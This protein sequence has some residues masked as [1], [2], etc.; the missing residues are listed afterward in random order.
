MS[1]TSKFREDLIIFCEG[2]GLDIGYGGDPI[3]TTSITIDLPIPYTKLGSYP[4][5]LGGDARKLYWFSD[6]SLNYVYSSHCLEDFE[7]TESVLTE[8]LRVLKPG[9]MLVLLL[10]DQQRYEKWC[11]DHKTEPNAAHKI[12]NFSLS[13][14]K[15]IVSKLNYVK[16]IHTKDI[17]EEYNFQIVLE[18]TMKIYHCKVVKLSNYFNKI[19]DI[20]KKNTKFR[21]SKF[22]ASK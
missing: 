2:Y 5:H 16:I 18:K 10:P 17:M 22:I 12:K 15:D 21:H 4:L 3:K 8:W 11:S 14:L 20:I 6:N 13:Y 19:F 7:D 9:G 1:E